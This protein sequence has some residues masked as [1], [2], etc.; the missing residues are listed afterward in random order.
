M[1][2]RNFTERDI[3]HRENGKVYVFPAKAISDDI[4]EAELS[5]ETL[6][7]YYRTAIALAHEGMEDVAELIKATKEEVPI[8]I[9]DVLEV[10]EEAG[11]AVETMIE[12]ATGKVIGTR[13]VPASVSVNAINIPV[14]PVVASVSINAIDVPVVS[15]V[16]DIV[17]DIDKILDNVEEVI[18]GKGK[19]KNNKKEA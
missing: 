10:I 3:V 11:D 16:E 6:K 19:A 5:Y 1:R 17:E 12:V 4:D 13:I 15:I 18:K 7:G 8:V 9:K 14:A 2:I